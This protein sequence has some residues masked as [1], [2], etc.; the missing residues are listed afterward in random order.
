[1]KHV[2]SRV[3]LL[4][5]LAVAGVGLAAFGAPDEMTPERRAA[6]RREAAARLRGSVSR[7]GFLEVFSDE[8][9]PADGVGFKGPVFQSAVDLLNRVE[10]VTALEMPRGGAGLVVYVG[11]G[12]NADSSVVS[13]VERKA[14]RGLVTRVYLPSPGF[15]DLDEFC[16]A[17]TAAYLRAWAWRTA[18]SA[19]F[20]A[21]IPEVPEWV[22][23]GLTRAAHEQLALFDR[24]RVLELW[25]NGELEY[26]PR[27]VEGMKLGDD[28]A[29]ALCGF[30]VKWSLERKSHGEESFGEGGERGTSAPT[31]FRQMMTRLA[32]GEAWDAGTFARLI[33]GNSDGHEQDRAC[34]LYLERLRRAVLVPGRATPEDVLAFAQRL[35]LHSPAYDTMFSGGGRTCELR[36]AVKIADDPVVRV[37]AY[38]KADSLMLTVIGRGDALVK[39]AESYVRFLRELA[40]GG[41]RG[42]LEEMLDEAEALLGAAYRKA[43]EEFGV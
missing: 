34:G 12:T 6:A 22:A 26:F 25:Q 31:P 16:R 8:A 2:L 23:C 43:E 38:L 36:R 33:A 20:S 1:M 27:L 11:A 14:S 15:S 17:V 21:E 32:K 41:S 3:V 39:A 19:S 24:L 29:P 35:V 18:E 28:P 37:A 5:V 4:A 7:D 42:K 30:L 40:R 13:K 9:E 10:A